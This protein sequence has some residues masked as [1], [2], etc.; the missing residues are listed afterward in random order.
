MSIA[1]AVTIRPSRICIIL[2]HAMCALVC[3]VG[4]LLACQPDVLP[5]LWAR[6]AI[7]SACLSGA[8]VA[9]WAWCRRKPTYRIEIDAQGHIYLHQSGVEDH[10]VRR[11]EKAQLL[12]S[13]TM[14]P[15]MMALRLR[16]PAG[17]QT[18]NILRDSVSRQEF[19]ALSAALRWV[20]TR[21][22]EAV[23]GDVPP[24]NRR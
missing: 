24:E 23:D 9:L 4:V 10:A 6:L 2:V 8:V 11:G 5:G 21:R 3:S 1:V 22:S 14:W 15:G 13:S 12:P 7:S 18:L 17:E 16:L 19:R 20:A